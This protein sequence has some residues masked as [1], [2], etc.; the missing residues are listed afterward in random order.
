MEPFRK[1][2]TARSDVHRIFLATGSLLMLAGLAA[3]LFIWPLAEQAQILSDRQHQVAAQVSALRS[4]DAAAQE[5]VKR[6]LQFERTNWQ[7]RL[8][9]RVQTPDVL[10]MLDA[11]ALQAGVR[12]MAVKPQASRPVGPLTEYPFEVTV[13]GDFFAAQQFL[14]QLET[15]AAPRVRVV[16]FTLS[17]DPASGLKQQYVL[18]APGTTAPAPVAGSNGRQKS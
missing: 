14:Q 10:R 5:V 15:K 7:Q 1:W 2:W 9:E 17:A 4:Q 18:A 12:I 16:G 11:T 6:Q 3:W 13:M 8:P